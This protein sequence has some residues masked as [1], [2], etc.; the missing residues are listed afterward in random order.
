MLLS[1]LSLTDRNHWKVHLD[2]LLKDNPSAKT[3]INRM[4]TSKAQLPNIKHPSY[5]HD[6]FERPERRK[7]I[8]A[9]L[10]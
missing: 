9:W 5:I 10:M 1:A 3:E 4:I 8:E 6:W 7:E 2:A